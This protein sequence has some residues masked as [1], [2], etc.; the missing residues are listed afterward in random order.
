MA[1]GGWRCVSHASLIHQRFARLAVRGLSEGE[2]TFDT[3]CPCLMAPC[4]VARGRTEFGPLGFG[5]GWINSL[6]LRVLA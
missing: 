6:Q 5:A 2:A 4:K 3:T 1:P